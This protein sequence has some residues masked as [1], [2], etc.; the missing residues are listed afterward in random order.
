MIKN[1]SG[2]ESV[3]IKGENH[4]VAYSNMLSPDWILA[5]VIPEKTLIYSNREI[6]EKM[7]ATENKMTKHFILLAIIFVLVSIPFMVLFF[8]FYFLNPL[9]NIRMG[10]R[11]IRKGDFNL[12]LKEN[13]AA[14]LADLSSA[15]NYLGFKL[16]DYIKNLKNEIKARQAVETEIEIAADMQRQILTKTKIRYKKRDFDLFAQLDA[17]KNVSGD[18]YDYFYLDDNR[19]ALLIADVSGKGLKAAF[20]MAM[21]KVLL[22]S[23]SYKYPDNPA[24]V[25]EESNRSLCL[26]N[27][28]QM[29]VTVFLAF[30]N[31]KTGELI[32]ANGG[33]HDAIIVSSTGEYEQFGILKNMALGY[34]PDLKYNLGRK[35]LKKEDLLVLFTD[36]VTEAISPEKEEYGLKRLEQVLVNNKN[37]TI[38]QVCNTVVKDVKAFEQGSQF[39]DIT[40]LTL[41]KNDEES[42]SSHNS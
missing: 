30:Y 31:F 4:I 14:E 24:L 7:K 23:N 15:F 10:I 21:S 28:A 6:K 37:L 17:A 22:K 41:K 16:N 35:K 33:H 27:E 20:F 29:F 19:L 40:L 3:N 42:F 9:T 13:G 38:E 1:S 8:R 39:D 5:L 34:T 11:K 36:G 25:L 26:D 18:F 12:Q 32:Y 2:I